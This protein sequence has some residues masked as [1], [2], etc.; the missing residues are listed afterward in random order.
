LCR[1]ASARSTSGG[2]PLAQPAAHPDE[3]DLPERVLVEPLAHELA[4]VLQRQVEPRRPHVA[5]EHRRGEVEHEHEVAD[6]RAPDRA[7]GG[8]QAM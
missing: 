4:R 8:K 2:Q 5:V 7:L 1:S 6:D 3:R